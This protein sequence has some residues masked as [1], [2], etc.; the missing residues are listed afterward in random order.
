M[1]WAIGVGRIGAVIAP[2]AAGALLDQAWSPSTI[3]GLFA[4]PLLIAVFA[5]SVVRR[6]TVD[7]AVPAALA[8]EVE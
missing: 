5:M 8:S 2:I 1:G 3:Y 4:V 6:G 7:L